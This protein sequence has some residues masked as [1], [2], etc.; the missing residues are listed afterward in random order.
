M[1]LVAWEVSLLCDVVLSLFELVFDQDFP[2][3]EWLL[4]FDE[5]IHYYPVEGAENHSF[6]LQKGYEVVVDLL[7]ACLLAN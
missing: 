6:H 7:I 1:F 5:V 3:F 4:V 2:L